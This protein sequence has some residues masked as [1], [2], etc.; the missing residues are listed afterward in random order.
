MGRCRRWIVG[1][2]F[3]GSNEPESIKVSFSDRYSDTVDLFFPTD[4]K[5]HHD[6]SVFVTQRGIYRPRVVAMADNTLPADDPET[7]TDPAFGE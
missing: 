7:A 1:R 5:Q 3:L 2:A 6:L 4:F